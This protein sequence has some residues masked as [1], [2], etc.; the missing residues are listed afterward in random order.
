MAT[1]ESSRLGKISSTALL[2]NRMR[3]LSRISFPL[4]FSLISLALGEHLFNIPLK[5]SIGVLKKAI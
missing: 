4:P 2:A 5:H 1:K 3:L